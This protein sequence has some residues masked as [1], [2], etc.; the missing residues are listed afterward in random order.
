[1]ICGRII[2]NGASVACGSAAIERGYMAML[3]VVVDELHRGKGYGR[4]IC[5]SLLSAAKRLDSHTAYLQVEQGNKKAVN[6]YAKLGYKNVY[7]YW[8]RVKKVGNLHELCH[9]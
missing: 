3:N 8:Y 7:S 4:E 5:E 9:Q 1:M 2:K 6:L